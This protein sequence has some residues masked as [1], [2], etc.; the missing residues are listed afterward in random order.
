MS[1]YLLIDF[2]NMA[3]RAHYAYQA[4]AGFTAPDGTPTG[5]T[6][7][8]LSMT[9]SLVRDTGATHVAFAAESRAR[10]LNAETVDR[11]IASSPVVAATFPAGYKGGRKE[12][13][14]LLRAQ[15]RLA[16]N[17][18]EAMGWPV[19]RTDG[20]EADDTLASL[21][22]QAEQLGHESIIVTGDQD[23]WQCVTEK[24]SV[25]QPGRGGVY[26]AVTPK[27][28]PE[29]LFGLKAEQIVELKAL[30]GD[31]SDGYPGC[32]GIGP[33]GAVALLKEYG[34]VDDIY[35]NID[36]VKGASQ[37][38]LIE[39][40]PLVRLSRDLAK[41]Y[42]QAPVVLDASA[43]EVSMPYPESSLQFVRELGM[44][45]LERRMGYAKTD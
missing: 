42:F 15:L 2:M 28:L 22:R 31:S 33:K 6:Y 12:M 32:P 9:L 16:E 34:T 18:C 27:T 39:N 44:K 4:Q 23:L 14:P 40:E 3:F 11:A 8:L 36:K 10:T 45:S 20:Y 25:W 38:R 35:V 24:I 19:Y 26:L 29:F 30:A 7:G 37:K 5:M 41:L 17:A 1:K 43:G 21:A 13:D